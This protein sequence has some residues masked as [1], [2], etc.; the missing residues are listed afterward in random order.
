MESW[1]YGDNVA[2]ILSEHGHIESDG[3]GGKRNGFQSVN[4]QNSVMELNWA[5]DLGLEAFSR[6]LF[7]HRLIHCDMHSG[8]L[9][10]NEEEKSL[11]ILDGGLCV[12]PNEDDITLFVTMLLDSWTGLAHNAA[13]IILSLDEQYAEWIKL[14]EIQNEHGLL[15]KLEDI[16]SDEF[17]DKMYE[18]IEEVLPS[19]VLRERAISLHRDL[20][21][22]FDENES[23]LEFKQKWNADKENWE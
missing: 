13:N 4:D 12:N 10:V 3:D 22:M 7:K 18:Y 20:I 17:R 1:E 5:I 15:Q 21:T 2:D 8:N 19:K 11:I 6:M 9:L 14:E 23:Y 16:D